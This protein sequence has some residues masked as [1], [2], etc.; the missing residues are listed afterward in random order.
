MLHNVATGTFESVARYEAVRVL[1]RLLLVFTLIAVPLVGAYR[2]FALH[3]QNKDLATAFM[4]SISYSI[5]L[6]DTFQIERAIE[7]FRDELGANS[8]LIQ[9]E[10]EAGARW[11]AVSPTRAKYF[12]HEQEILFRS[13]GFN[14]GDRLFKIL[15]V[16][17]FPLGSMFYQLGLTLLIALTMFLF[18]SKQILSL[19]K[20]LSQP[21]VDLSDELASG[22]VAATGLSA[23]TE[24]EVLRGR[25]K[26]YEQKLK[27][28][29][30]QLS[31]LTVQ[32]EKARIAHQVA[33]D[34]RS[35]LVVFNMINEL[36]PDAPED[37]RRILRLAAQRVHDIANDLIQKV[38]VPQTNA[39]SS[40][41]E[42]LM[43]SDLVD[44]VVSEKRM[45]I[46][47]EDQVMIHADLKDAYGAF[48]EL[49]SASRIL[50]AISNGLNNA[51][52][53]LSTEG[54][55]VKVSMR[56][57]GTFHEIE[58]ADNGCGIPASILRRLGAERL[59]F[60]PKKS[61]SGSGIGLMQIKEALEAEGGTMRI[62]SEEGQGTVLS[63]SLP[64][65]SPPGWFVPTIHIKD[66][67]TIVSVDDDPNIH[68]VWMHRMSALAVDGV[69]LFHKSFYSL[70]EAKFWLDDSELFRG[71]ILCLVDYEFRGDVSTSALEFISSL[72]GHV[73]AILVTSRSQDPTL[74]KELASRSIQMI[75]K[76]GASFVEIALQ[77]APRNSFRPELRV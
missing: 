5:A 53:S 6:N 73:R 37:K 57:W 25:V 29:A 27:E 56:S 18:L 46:P 12:L 20:R 36:L 11:V 44:T 40:G 54:G 33:H 60:G 31:A 14:G 75:P 61:G 2:Y 3:Q 7:G 15:L 76:Q 23:I 4:S 13:E 8:I 1:K 67:T 64:Q 19:M 28:N 70:E 9:E 50:R 26:S 10:K 74:L 55:V 69:K 45:Q 59:T 71:D 38:G 52:D 68:Q 24:I 58:I 48:V 17:P 62:E 30:Q 72:P 35:P 51:I 43:L 34:I 41:A 63:L 47:D 65:A 21:I 32:E 16:V 66:G 77:S 49:S 22:F 39:P 42:I